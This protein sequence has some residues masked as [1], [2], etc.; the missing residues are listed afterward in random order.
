MALDSSEGALPFPEPPP[1]PGG[2]GGASFRGGILSFILSRPFASS[3]LAILWL[4]ENPASA[5]KKVFSVS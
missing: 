3:K 5:I 2:G 1:P 4:G